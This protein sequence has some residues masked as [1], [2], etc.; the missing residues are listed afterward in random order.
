M[1]MIDQVLRPAPP[2]ID[3]VAADVGVTAAGSVL[4]VD[5]DDGDAGRM[6]FSDDLVEGVGVAMPPAM[7]AQ[8]L[9]PKIRIFTF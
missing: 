6:R 8:M 1:A 7:A 5:D 9:D 2:D 3:V 4:G